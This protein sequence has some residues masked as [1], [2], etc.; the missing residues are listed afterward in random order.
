MC[1]TNHNSLLVVEG[2]HDFDCS[3]YRHATKGRMWPF[4]M[5]FDLPDIL[6][7]LIL[8]RK[9][10]ENGSQQIFSCQHTAP[11]YH[12]KICKPREKD[13]NGV[14]IKDLIEDGYVVCGCKE[15]NI[16]P[17]RSEGCTRT[18]RRILDPYE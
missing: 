8:K 15:G 18:Y 6:Q 1:D 14:M 16:T 4:D 7:S 3:I 13:D 9:K 10:Y 2:C 17:I 11:S 12:E 5:Q